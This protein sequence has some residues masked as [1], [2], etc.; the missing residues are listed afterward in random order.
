MRV[1]QSIAIAIVVS[2]ACVLGANAQDE[3]T[4]GDV[5]YVLDGRYGLTSQGYVEYRKCIAAIEF[6]GTMKAYKAALEQCKKEAK[7]KAFPISPMTT[8]AGSASLPEIERHSAALEVPL[9]SNA[10]KD[11]AWQ[12]QILKK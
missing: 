9:D 3:I 1:R 7:A 6:G 10:I 11:R 12:Q 8:P 5:R 2:S 4:G